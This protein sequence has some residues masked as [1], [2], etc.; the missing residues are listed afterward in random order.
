M[1]N[2]KYIGNM[3]GLTNEFYR[4][5]VFETGEFERPIFDC[6]SFVGITS[7]DAELQ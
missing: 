2:I 5:I 7:V 6:M 1:F 3:Q 4:S